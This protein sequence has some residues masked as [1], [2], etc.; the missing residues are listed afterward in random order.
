MI[1]FFCA[2]DTRAKTDGLLGDVA[3]RRVVEARDLVAGDD[4]VVVETDAPA[5]VAG[6]EIVV[7]G[8]DLHGDAVA[9][10]LARGRRRHPAAP[11]RRS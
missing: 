6:D 1:R 7:A 2:G 3:E 9:L 10:E 11:G 4:L 5:H 8:Q